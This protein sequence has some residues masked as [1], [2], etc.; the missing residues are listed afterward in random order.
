MSTTVTQLTPIFMGGD[1]ASLQVAGA[2]GAFIRDPKSLTVGIRAKGAP[3]PFASM[4]GGNPMGLLQLVAITASAN[5][6]KPR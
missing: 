1:P 3:I 2:L 6:E 4:M 5:G